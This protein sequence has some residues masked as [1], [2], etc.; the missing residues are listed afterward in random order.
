MLRIDW[1][2][3]KITLKQFEEFLSPYLGE[4][5]DGLLLENN[6]V[7]VRTL[8][9]QISPEQESHILDY[10]YSLITSPA[11][12]DI[13]SQ[14]PFAAKT[15]T[16]SDGTIKKLYKRITGIQQELVQGT[17]TI[18][19][20]IPFPWCKITGI[21]LINGENL[22]TACLYVLDDINGTY[23][24]IPNYQLNQ[25]SYS[26]NASKDYYKLESEYDA[27]LYYGMQLKITYNSISA[28]IIGI[29][30]LLNEVKS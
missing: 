16:L 5:Y 8:N 14:A 1:S 25:F 11:K 12:V 6:F 20:T 26:A 3:P 7:Y 4:N 19:F 9:E 29:N 21:E 2:N 18:L 22:D 17:N 27:D 24:S 15:I 23:S 28:K 30:F 13:S 10:V